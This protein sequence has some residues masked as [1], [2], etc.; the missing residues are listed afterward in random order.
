MTM[1]RAEALAK[2]RAALAASPSASLDATL[3]LAYLLGLSRES[4]ILAP[5][6][7]L[8]D[9]L[10]ESYEAALAARASGR[11][12]AYLTGEKEFYGRS[13]VVSEAVLIPRPDTELLVES[14]L[15]LGDAI[16]ARLRGGSE[17]GYRPL[18]VHE[19]C[20]GSGAVAISLAAERPAWTVT[21]SDISAAALAVASQNAA[22]LLPGDRPG[23]PLLLSSSDLLEG[24]GDDFDLILANPPYVESPLARE[25]S[26]TW[27]EPLL[28]LDGGAEG[29]DLL[30]RLVPLAS[31]RLVRG[32]FLLVEADGDQAAALRSMFAA[33]GLL[34]AHSERDLAGIER[35]TIGELP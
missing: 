5:R 7:R 20:V 22:R 31:T 26:E 21:A 24:I 18:R 10:L 30:R 25:L 27:G 17:A 28:A 15:G 8:P 32:G 2:G 11:P 13:F 1:T 19:C 4:L 34:G 3:I 12:V 16:E 6:E 29:L 35:V 33:A 14:A 9:G 23:G